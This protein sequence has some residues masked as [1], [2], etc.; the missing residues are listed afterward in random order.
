MRRCK[1]LI[2]FDVRTP[3]DGDVRIDSHQKAQHR[4]IMKRQR[5]FL[6][7]FDTSI[8]VGVWERDGKGQTLLFLLYILDEYF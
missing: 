1:I 5:L 3:C 4:T 7:R 6:S 2:P 8:D